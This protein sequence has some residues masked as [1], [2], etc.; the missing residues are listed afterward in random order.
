V[1][2][3]SLQALRA[4]APAL[5]A[6]LLVVG[7][8][9]GGSRAL[10]RPSLT[11]PARAG[12]ALATAPS[13]VPG[14]AAEQPARPEETRC[15]PE[16]LFGA[17]ELTIPPPVE[18]ARRVREDPNGLGSA[19]IG[20]PTRGALW[21]AVQ[22]LPSEGIE[23]AGNHPW[24]TDVA[25]HSIERAVRE[26]RRCFPDTPKLFVGDISRQTGGW[27]RPHK[28]H[29]S[30]LDAD[31]GYYYTNGAA[32][33]Q[34][35]TADNLDVARTWAM[36][37]SFIEGGHVEVIFV[38]R[39]VQRLLRTHAESIGETRVALDEVFQSD[40]RRDT[41]VRH[42]PG[43]TSHFHVRFR[44]PTSTALGVRLAPMLRGRVPPPPPA[45]PRAPSKNPLTV[46][47]RGGRP[48]LSNRPAGTAKKPPSS[49]RP[50]AS[51]GSRR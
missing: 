45:K 26:V 41:L 30:G 1:L 18:L 23:T 24:G 34:H 11:E 17:R 25:V 19:S 9:V 42:A 10:R 46:S 27:L 40:D 20:T 3:A 36:I 51:P 14:V 13:T 33:F 48:L 47:Q 29:Q 38:D 43:H 31:V 35:A 44:D 12:V 4:A 32:W 16:P 49:S 22:L 7:V 6:A 21:G 50:A 37:V 39:T 28:S 8:G 15:P 5:V 2:T